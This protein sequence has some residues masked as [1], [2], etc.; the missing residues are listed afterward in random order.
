MTSTLTPTCSLCGLRFEN[1]P[2]L[3]LHLREDHPQRGPTTEP[4]RGVPAGATAPAGTLDD[5]PAAA[6]RSADS[7]KAEAASPGTAWPRP[8]AGW[9][10]TRLRRMA[11]AFRRAN[12]ELMLAWELL[13]RPAGRP[14]PTPPATPPAG[15]DGHRP[16]ARGR[17]G[18]AA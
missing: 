9:I 5:Q 18:R 17:M 15:A 13:A 11:G 2:L 12:A 14:R 8:R 16:V 4:G 1:R 7:A 10:I 6:G 3:D